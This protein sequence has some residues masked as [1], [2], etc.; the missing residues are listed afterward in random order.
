L[1]HRQGV[2]LFDVVQLELQARVFSVI[3]DGER[4]SCRRRLRCHGF[5]FHDAGVLSITED[6]EPGNGDNGGLVDT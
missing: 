3:A 5:L 6:G 1:L 2:H 4:V